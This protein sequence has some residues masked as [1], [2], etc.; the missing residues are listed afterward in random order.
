MAQQAML[1]NELLG[2]RD[3]SPA[4][5]AFTDAAGPQAAQ[6][7]PARIAF[8]LQNSVPDDL[9]RFFNSL[10]EAASQTQRILADAAPKTP[11]NARAAQ[12]AQALTEHIDFVAQMKTM[13]YVQVPLFADGHDNTASLY[14]FKDGKRDR[15][16]KGGARSALIALDTAYLGHFE[17]YVQKD[18]HSVNCQF[19]LRDEAVER[20]VRENIHKLDALLAEYR[21]SLAAYSFLP[22]GKPF[23]L[24]DTPDVFGAGG[25]EAEKTFGFDK[26]V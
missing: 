24:L 22:S 2:E 20:L 14:I 7:A 6:P 13:H 26:R 8:Q 3:T 18:G 15:Q 17:A 4:R 19:R 16:N 5:R 25:P 11:E 1:F 10:R 23:T 9:D 12:Q 21:L